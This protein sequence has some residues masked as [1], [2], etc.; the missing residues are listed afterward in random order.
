MSFANELRTA[1]LR[2]LAML[3]KDCETDLLLMPYA[4]FSLQCL[5]IYRDTLYK[6]ILRKGSPLSQAFCAL[7]ID[8]KLDQLM[9]FL[10][11]FYLYWH[12][13]ADT[14]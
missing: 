1:H 14:P 5:V 13:Q 8:E 10:E 4:E 9:I 2:F 12:T 11:T 6:G 3:R 7:N